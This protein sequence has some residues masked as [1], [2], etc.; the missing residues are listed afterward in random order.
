MVDI[1]RLRKK[2]VMSYL[3]SCSL[4]CFDAVHCHIP[5]YA[6]KLIKLKPVTI[7]CKPVNKQIYKSFSYHETCNMKIRDKIFITFVFTVVI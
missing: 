1:Q 4:K 2:V 5:L 6:Y 3:N 7:L